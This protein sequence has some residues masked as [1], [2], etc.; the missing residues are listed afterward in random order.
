M[1]KKKGKKSNKKNEKY[2]PD[3][4]VLKQI[5]ELLTYRMKAHRYPYSELE[6]DI[7]QSEETTFNCMDLEAMVKGEPFFLKP[8]FA[9]IF[10]QYAFENEH[11]PIDG[12]ISNSVFLTKMRKLI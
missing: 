8:E 4:K 11:P 5:R 10:L 1:K 12:V 7:N 2:I 3:K 9:K 6:K